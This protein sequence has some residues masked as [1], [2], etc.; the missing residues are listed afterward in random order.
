VADIEQ[1]IID[2]E[3]EIARLH[4]LLALPE[5]QRAGDRVRDLM[6]QV[7]QRQDALATLYAHWEEATEL[8]W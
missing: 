1:D 6:A 4:H 5:T 3:M 2:H 7:Q 8:N